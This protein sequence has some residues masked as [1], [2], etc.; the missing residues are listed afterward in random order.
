MFF[1]RAFA[2]LNLSLLVSE[3]RSNDFHEISSVFQSISLADDLYIRE[4]SERKLQI[5]C[6]FPDYPCDQRNGL[7]K[8]YSFFSSQLECGFEI[9]VFKR[10]PIGA[11]LG[12]AS[13]QMACFLKFLFERYSIVKTFDDLRNLS[14]RFGSDVPFFFDGGQAYVTGFGDNIEPIFLYEH[15]A[16]IL[17]FPPVSLLTSHVY[18][19]FDELKASHSFRDSL[20][21]PIGT[22]DLLGAALDLEP[23]LALMLETMSSLCHKPLFMSGSGSTFYMPFQILEEAQEL[24]HKLFPFQ[25]KFSMCFCHST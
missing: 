5:I 25:Q 7:S 1:L 24:Y 20:T 13:S 17:F 18:K 6:D 15:A 19:R 9:V 4:I 22:N 8:I 23:S 16:Y 14:S 12:G 21:C 3:K 2:K 11:G 10:V